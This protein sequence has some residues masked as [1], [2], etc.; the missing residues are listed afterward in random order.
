MGEVA[1]LLGGKTSSL[2]HER[3]S[4]VRGHVPGVQ[5][6]EDAAELMEPV[7]VG[8]VRVFVAAAAG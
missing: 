8:C 3:L 6:G 7:P 1:V 5:G 2:P 4:D